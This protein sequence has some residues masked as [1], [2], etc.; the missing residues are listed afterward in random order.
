MKFLKKNEKGQSTI[1]FVITF[2]F[3]MGMTFLFLG[4][5]IN[6][7]VGYLVHYGTFMASRTYLVHDRPSSTNIATTLNSAAAA[8][9]RTYGLYNLDAFDAGDVQINNPAEIRPLF[10]G[11]V[12]TFQRKISFVK[13]ISGSKEATL[14]SESMLGKEP[15]RGECLQSTC[16]AMG[17]TTNCSESMDITLY[18]NGC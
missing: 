7:V 14:V 16:A 9:K 5:A 2:G 3:S 18:D 4:M 13:F 10:A 17:G 8:A 1:E 6:Y 15:M 11:A 12:T